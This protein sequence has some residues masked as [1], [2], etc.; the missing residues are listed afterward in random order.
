MVGNISWGI[1]SLPSIGPPNSDVGPPN[2][3]EVHVGAP[4]SIELNK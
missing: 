4:N 2:S 1:G 3:I